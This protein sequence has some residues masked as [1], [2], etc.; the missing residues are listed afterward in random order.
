M[1]PLRV[2]LKVDLFNL[3]EVSVRAVTFALF[4]VVELRGILQLL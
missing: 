1:H 2:A 4:F 3:I